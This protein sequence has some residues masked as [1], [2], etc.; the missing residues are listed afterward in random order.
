MTISY[1]SES[2]AQILGYLQ[3]ELIDSDIDTLMPNEMSDSHNN[4]L[5]N[6]L[7]TLQ[8]AVNDCFKIQNENSIRQTKND[9]KIFEVVRPKKFAL[10]SKFEGDLSTEEENIFIKRKRYKDKRSRRENQ[11][12]IRKKIKREFL[13]NALIPKINMII[14]KHGGKFF[15]DIF[16]QDFVSDVTRKRN[17]ELYNMTLGEIFKKKELYHQKELNSYY[18][19]LK[20]INS[21]EIQENKE[22]KNIFNLTLFN[23]FEEY[24][25]SNEFLIEEVNRLKDK[26]MDD[27][28]IQR[29]IILA[30]NYLKFI[31]EENDKKYVIE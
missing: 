5:L 30:K 9:I 23:I 3:S 1:F 11:D 8:K 16:K 7:I 28:Y 19:N 26:K 14:K 4:M 25:N 10:F 18:F 22:L 20:L 24:L 21:K 13:N 12:N 15:F 31:H 29:Y 6:Y 17:K 2:L 27:L